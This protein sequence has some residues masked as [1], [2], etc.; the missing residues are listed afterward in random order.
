MMRGD[1]GD[2]V[3]K[4]LFDS[5]ENRYQNNLESVRGSDFVFNYVQ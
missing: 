5:H 2:E 1:E 4:K 3:I